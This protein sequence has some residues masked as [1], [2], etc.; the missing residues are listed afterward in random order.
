MCLSCLSLCTIL[1]AFCN[2]FVLV[3]V[4]YSLAIILMGKRELIVLL[5]LAVWCCETVI[6][7]W[8]LLMVLLLGLQVCNY[9]IS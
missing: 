6:V 1:A 9:G 3:S 8:L 2:R 7:L 4:L 5:Q